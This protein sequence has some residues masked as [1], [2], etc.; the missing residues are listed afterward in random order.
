MF[1]PDFLRLDPQR[2]AEI[3]E[4]G[5]PP[6]SPHYE[7]MRRLRMPA[8]ALLLRRMELQLLAL[9]GQLRAGA[10]WAAIAAEHHSDRP[11]CTEL[12][13]EDQAFHARRRSRASR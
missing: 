6:R 4:A 9:L 10:R 5:Y 8:Q 11:S 2:V 3:V 1:A 7:L 13:R 12:G